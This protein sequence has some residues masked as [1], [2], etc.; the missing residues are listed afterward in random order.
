MLAAML[1]PLLGDAR[2]HAPRHTVDGVPS[3]LHVG[4]GIGPDARLGDLVRHMSAT[5]QQIADAHA[6]V[7][8]E[9]ASE[10]YSVLGE[11]PPGQVLLSCPWSAHGRVCMVNAAGVARQKLHRTSAADYP[12]STC[13]TIGRDN[14]IYTL[15]RSYTTRAAAWLCRW[16]IA[17]LPSTKITFE[18]EL[19]L[20]GLSC[21]MLASTQSANYHIYDMA[22][23]ADGMFVVLAACYGH[24]AYT[25]QHMDHVDIYLVPE[26]TSGLMV[27]AERT[28]RIYI[29]NTA[30][31]CELA[32]AE[33]RIFDGDG[34]I[35]G[36]H[37]RALQLAR[38]CLDGEGNIIITM[39]MRYAT[40]SR[41]D[42]IL[43][44]HVQESTRRCT[45][46]FIGHEQLAAIPAGLRPDGGDRPCVVA[47]NTVL[48]CDGTT[49]C[50][51]PPTLPQA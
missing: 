20:H 3:V 35:V 2:L 12:A 38:M 7:N 10:A 51:E 32:R 50:Y 48:L 18:H 15:H 30:L 37:D 46:H 14:N 21:T 19:M 9:T 17:A 1:L 28:L 31:A 11:W 45:S 4:D 16:R 44:V 33:R 13:A 6:L 27:Q 42:A 40:S 49:I 22:Q 34:V 39:C 25:E 24:R 43:V 8:I 5:T 47:A 29:D 41:G 26:R 23:R 36:G